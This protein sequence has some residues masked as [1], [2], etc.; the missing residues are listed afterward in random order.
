ML[1]KLDFGHFYKFVVSLGLIIVGIGLGLPLLVL[2][3]TDS[4]L[5]K[6][7]DLS[8]LTPTARKVVQIKQGHQLWIA[9][10]YVCISLVLCIVGVL[11]ATV[12]SLKWFGRQRVADSIE[13]LQRDRDKKALEQM[14]PS[15]IERKLDDEVAEAVAEPTAEISE[16]SDEA[17]G[18]SM[19]AGVD[20]GIESTDRPAA[21]SEE[22]SPSTRGE[23]D[24]QQVRVKS[25]VRDLILSGRPAS[26]VR[27]ALAATE[28]RLGDLFDE[29][30][31]ADF[32]V[33][34]NVRLRGNPRFELDML[35]TPRVR[36]TRGYLAEY[37]YRPSGNLPTS[38]LTKSIQQLASHVTEVEELLS[39][40][41]E[42]ILIFVLGGEP[43]SSMSAERVEARVRRNLADELVHYRERSA[44]PVQV[45][46]VT[47]RKL[48]RLRAKDVRRAVES[49]THSAPGIEIL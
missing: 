26:E 25:A 29:A 49:P 15:Q 19:S 4:L 22:T 31:G 43:Y 2:R 41:I 1:P 40:P 33:Y 18:P 36:G 21:G 46:L 38:I 34:R 28:K 7:Q 10:N 8:K 32:T 20:T 14:S 42:G 48:R 5:L 44:T 30:L 6:R 23:P 39:E 24:A 17:G 47:E 12:A 37:K 16:T 35:A 27:D 11:I 9:N 45:W 13:D 3:S